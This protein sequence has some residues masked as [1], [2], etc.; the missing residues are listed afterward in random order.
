M[1][2]FFSAKNNRW[3]KHYSFFQPFLWKIT[4]IY[5]MNL[6]LLNNKNN[7]LIYWIIYSQVTFIKS[8]TLT[9]DFSCSN[10]GDA[11]RLLYMHSN[12]TSNKLIL[13]QRKTAETHYPLSSNFNGCYWIPCPKTNNH[14]MFDHKREIFSGFSSLLSVGKRK[15]HNTRSCWRIH[16]SYTFHCLI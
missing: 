7:G 12:L 9:L 5:I 11:E 15:C 3:S 1:Q 13:L 8:F 14:W 16:M 10:K 4:Y 6:E 2:I